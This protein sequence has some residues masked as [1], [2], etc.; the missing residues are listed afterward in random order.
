MQRV[1]DA[2]R[3]PLAVLVEHLGDE[4]V[5]HPRRDANSHAIVLAPED[6]AGAMGAMSALVGDVVVGA[7][8][9]KILDR[10]GD[11]LKSRMAPVDAGVEQGDRDAGAVIRRVRRADRGDAPGA[12]GKSFLRF[13]QRRR[14]GTAPSGPGGACSGF[15]RATDR[16]SATT[17]LLGSSR[18]VLASSWVA[19]TAFAVRTCRV[20]PRPKPSSLL[21]RAAWG[22]IVAATLGVWAS[23]GL[24]DRRTKFALFRRAARHR[25]LLGVGD[26]LAKGRR[27]ASGRWRRMSSSAAAAARTARYRA[28][29]GRNGWRRRDRSGAGGRRGWRWRGSGHRATA[30]SDAP[31]RCGHDLPP[32][33]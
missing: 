28:A 29:A 32:V 3:R 9:G 19:A 1:E 22:K 20:A 31:R 5:G 2:D 18:R 15:T 6:H 26:H 10:E 14:A 4:R 17:L 27:P 7:A 24:S 12:A 21:K 11:A 8:A 30:P 23:A 33:R 16:R 25:G 13:G